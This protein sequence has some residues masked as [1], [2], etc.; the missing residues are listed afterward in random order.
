MKNIQENKFKA[1][2]GFFESLRTGVNN[3]LQEFT[4]F[5]NEKKFINI[6]KR[7]WEKYNQAY[8]HINDLLEFEIYRGLQYVPGPRNEADPNEWCGVLYVLLPECDKAIEGLKSRISAAARHRFLKFEGL[9]RKITEVIQNIKK[10]KWFT[11]DNPLVW[12]IFSLIFIVI[13]Y[14]VYKIL[15]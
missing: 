4:D 13:S 11:M 12:F 15:K 3:A 9:K 8:S 2:I 10:K 6:S 5:K 7:L 1:E 14:F